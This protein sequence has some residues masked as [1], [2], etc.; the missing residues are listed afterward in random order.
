MWK[1]IIVASIDM[2]VGVGGSKEGEVRQKL[3]NIG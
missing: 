1:E 2:S 3:H